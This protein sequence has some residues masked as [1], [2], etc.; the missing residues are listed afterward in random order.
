MDCAAF[1]CKLH[2]LHLGGSAPVCDSDI[3]CLEALGRL[4]GETHIVLPFPAEDLRRL[5]ID[6]SRGE[7]GAR[8]ERV[9][10]AANSVTVTSDHR[11][12]GS[13]ATFEYAS[14]VVT[15]M[16]RLRARLLRTDLRGVSIGGGGPTASDGGASSLLR[17]W[18]SQDVDVELVPTV[19]PRMESRG[20][21]ST[22][23][24]GVA[25]RATTSNRKPPA[26]IAAASWCWPGCVKC[27]C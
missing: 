12:R 3:L 2:A 27:G 5:R 9:L 6:L 7:W 8:F 21:R 19:A 24:A 10:A 23:P 13:A 16:A 4:G 22:I 18:R 1:A 14:L 26:V 17:I 25:R 15:G 11:A 20:A